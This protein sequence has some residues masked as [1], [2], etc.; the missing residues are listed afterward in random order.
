MGA[1]MVQMIGTS[2]PTRGANEA[3]R[4]ELL[5]KR[6]RSRVGGTQPRE[7]RRVRHR[8]TRHREGPCAIVGGA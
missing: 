6:P 4:F 1:K 5:P 8:R 3:Q 2:G 7:I